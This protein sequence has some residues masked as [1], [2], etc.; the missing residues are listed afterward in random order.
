MLTNSDDRHKKCTRQAERVVDDG[1]SDFIGERGNRRS[2][3]VIHECA[4]LKNK[5]KSA[6]DDKHKAVLSTD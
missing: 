2:L 1:G 5:V 4:V 3:V 6:S